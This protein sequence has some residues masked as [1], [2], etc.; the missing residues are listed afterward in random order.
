KKIETFSK[1]G[2]SGQV[3][4]VGMAC[5]FPGGANSP[6]E[7][8]TKVLAPAKDC[9]GMP[10]PGRLHSSSGKAWQ[11]GYIENV[12]LFDNDKFGISL[13]EAEVMHPAQRHMLEVGY[14]ALMSAGFTKSELKGERCGVFVGASSTNVFEWKGHSAHAAMGNIESNV[15]NRL[16]Y[17]LGLTGPSYVIDSACSASLVALDNAC[18]NLRAGLCDSAGKYTCVFTYKLL[19]LYDYKSFMLHDFH[20]WGA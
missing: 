7:L 3:A 16:S 15:A 4:V 10:P 11:S 17:A 20:L 1:E 8:W 6:E 5:R 19:W 12:E 2:S 14:Q 18:N 9:I 13:E